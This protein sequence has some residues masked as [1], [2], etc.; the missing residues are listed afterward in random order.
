METELLGV[1]PQ[2][3]KSVGN[4]ATSKSVL[5]V[6]PGRLPPVRLNLSIRPQTVRPQRKVKI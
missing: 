3:P 6:R 2:T 1:T 5:A 4:T